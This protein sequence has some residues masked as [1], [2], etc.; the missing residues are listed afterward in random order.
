MAGVLTV[1]GGL[2][3]ASAAEDSRLLF[4]AVPLGFAAQQA[5]E[6][7]VW[8]AIGNPTHH[9]ALRLAVLAFLSFALVVWPTWV[10]VSL[11]VAERDQQRRRWLA[12]LVGAGV[13]VSAVAVVLLARW[14]PHARIGGHSLRYSFGVET[15]APVHVVLIVAYI[16]PTLV[17]FFVSTIDLSA[18]FGISLIVSLGIALAIRREALTSVWCF[19]AAGLSVLVFVSVR[20]ASLAARRSRATH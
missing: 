5:I 1:V 10:P 13:V 11:W 7:G 8:L 16:V 6:G 3:I 18:V 20:R 4:A 17:P 9:A 19:F 14:E 15:G 12:W 2:S